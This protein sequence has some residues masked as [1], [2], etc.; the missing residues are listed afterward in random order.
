M[1]SRQR[2]KQEN[3]RYTI[4][5]NYDKRSHWNESDKLVKKILSGD[6]SAHKLIIRSHQTNSL[7]ITKQTIL[8]HLLTSH[9]TN[10]NHCTN[11][12]SIFN[13]S[14]EPLFHGSLHT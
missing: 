7:D 11:D 14:D 8:K 5:R 4:S 12:T 1:L 6:P 2:P 13:L 9:Q 10:T 3:A